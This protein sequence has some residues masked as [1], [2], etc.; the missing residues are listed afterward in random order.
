MKKAT[1]EFIAACKNSAGDEEPLFR[2]FMVTVTNDEREL[3]LETHAFR[4]S[5]MTARECENFAS[6]QVAEK[7]S[8]KANRRVHYEARPCNGNL[9]PIRFN[10]SC[11]RDLGR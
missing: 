9:Q 3:I 7:F 2:L 5:P 6:A 8:K 4:V 10:P 1:K 11:Y